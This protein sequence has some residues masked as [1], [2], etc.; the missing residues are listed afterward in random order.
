MALNPCEHIWGFGRLTYMSRYFIVNVLCRKLKRVSSKPV[1]GIVLRCNS[2]ILCYLSDALK[3]KG[4][5]KTNWSIC[6]LFH[7]PKTIEL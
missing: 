6:D 3:C 5:H 2:S 7:M 1:D 4:F